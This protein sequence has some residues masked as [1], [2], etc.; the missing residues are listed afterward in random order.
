MIEDLFNSRT[1]IIII[2]IIWGL[3]L[4]TIFR[5]ACQGRKCQVVVYNG[6]NPSEVKSTY[7]EYGNGQCY[8]YSPF[9]SKCGWETPN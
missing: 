9:A 1:G 6:P 4:S 3:G 8:Q 7:Y 2:S 5:K